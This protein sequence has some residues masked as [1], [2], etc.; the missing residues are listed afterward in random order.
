MLQ[1][2]TITSFSKYRALCFISFIAL[3]SASG[4]SLTE[5]LST[6]TVIEI[7]KSNINCATLLNDISQGHIF[8]PGNP[9]GPCAPVSP[10]QQ[11]PGGPCGPCC[12]C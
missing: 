1:I 3:A 7:F 4:I 9:C 11:H 8:P 5:P 12:S 2:G 10:P 6:F